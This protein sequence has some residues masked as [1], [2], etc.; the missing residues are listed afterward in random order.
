LTTRALPLGIT[1]GDPAGIGPEVILRSLDRLPRLKV[2]IIGPLAVFER[3][4]RQLKTRVDLGLVDDALQSPGRFDYGKV[5][6]NCGTTALLALEL[7]THLLKNNEI[8]ALV[9]APVSKEA[10]R[11]AGFTFPGQ[12]EF[13]ASRLG[14]HR[15]A[16]LA[17]TPRFKAVF[18]TIHLPLAHASRHITPDAVLEKIRL[19][20]EFLR[21]EASGVKRPPIGVLAFNP[22]AREFSLGEE[23]WIAEAVASARKTGIDAYG[24]IPADAA[25]ASAAGPTPRYAAFVAMY[26][27]QAMIPAK[28]LGRDAGVNATLGLGR[29]RTSPL[30]GTAFDIAGKGIARPDST[31]AAIRL[32]LRLARAR[33]A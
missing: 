11:L 25:L 14:A 24:P 2:R 32:A 29:I 31:L 22:H 9:T 18:V 12:T 6:R 8:S 13:L 4:Q 7:G 26:H 3:A 16:M 21:R 27:D 33:T 17:W 15:T 28:L 10:L 23:D 19:L 5:Q 1:V 30:H 20:D